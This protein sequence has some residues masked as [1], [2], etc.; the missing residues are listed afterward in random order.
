MQFKKVCF[1]CFIK[2]LQ[3][4]TTWTI[5]HLYHHEKRL[6]Q[7]GKKIL[8]RFLLSNLST[9]PWSDK[10]H[11]SMFFPVYTQ[12]NWFQFPATSD[13]TRSRLK[14]HSCPKIE[15]D[16]DWFYKQKEDK[17]QLNH[18]PPNLKGKKYISRSVW[19]WAYYNL[20][21]SCNGLKVI[22]SIYI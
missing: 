15:W 4:I 10:K 20:A 9:C 22:I 21:F 19:I 16:F 7:I 8:P 6:L 5:N 3:I 14:S 1:A 11:K 12:R 18:I 2:I 13:G 17:S